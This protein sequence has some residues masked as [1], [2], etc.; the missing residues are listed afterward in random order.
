MFHNYTSLLLVTPVH[1]YYHNYG[2]GFHLNPSHPLEEQ[3]RIIGFPWLQS[4]KMDV[5]LIN[6]WMVHK[7]LKHNSTW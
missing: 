1:Y 2:C 5:L 7:I 4:N 3:R 6:L